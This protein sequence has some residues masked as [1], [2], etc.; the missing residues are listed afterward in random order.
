MPEI[1]ILC[2]RLDRERKVAVVKEVTEGFSRASGIEPGHVTVHIQEHS[3]DNIGVGGRVLT[4]LYPELAE[5][6]R[7]ATRGT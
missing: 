1:I 4:D 6:E 3:Y 5:R 2:P 7:R